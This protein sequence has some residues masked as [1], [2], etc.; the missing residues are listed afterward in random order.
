MLCGGQ[1]G[2]ALDWRALLTLCDVVQVWRCSLLQTI[3][4]ETFAGGSLNDRSVDLL[5]SLESI[6]GTES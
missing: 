4:L 1:K 2:L 6:N 3:V 5:D